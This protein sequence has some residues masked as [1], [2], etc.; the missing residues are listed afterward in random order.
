MTLGSKF[1]ATRE[2]E[3][4]RDPMRRGSEWRQRCFAEDLRVKSSTRAR[5]EGCQRSEQTSVAVLS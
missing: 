5:Q 2:S 4:A 1:L 3:K